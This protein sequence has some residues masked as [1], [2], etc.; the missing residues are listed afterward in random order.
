MLG[1]TGV[2]VP[3]LVHH[4]APPAAAPTSTNQNLPF[5]GIVQSRNGRHVYVANFANDTVSVIDPNRRVVDGD[6]IP[7]GGRPEGMAVTADDRHVYVADSDDSSVSVIDTSSHQVRR[8]TVPRGPF[9]VT[10]ELDRPFVYVTN[11]DARQVTVINAATGRTARRPI[12]LHGHPL[13]IAVHPQGHRVYVVDDTG[14][15]SI[16]DT[17]TSRVT[18]VPLPGGYPYGL[19]T[20]PAGVHLYVTTL[21]PDTLVTIDTATHAI[22]GSP[23]RVPGGPFSVATTRGPIVYVASFDEN[24]VITVDTA[25]GRIIGDPIHVPISPRGLM[26]VGDRWL[27]VADGAGMVSVVDTTTHTTVGAPIVLAR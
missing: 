19:T 7:V 21:R 27:Y 11:F 17:A 9:A 25:H 8:I 5:G 3:R 18:E 20:D 4:T 16:I 12:S 24:S 13:G 26:T 15:L 6:P 14:T 22:V 10:A 23:V 1:L 2:F